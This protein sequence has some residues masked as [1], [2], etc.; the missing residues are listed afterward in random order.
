MQE[1]IYKNLSLEDLSGE[2]WR[3]V[4]GYEG[5]Y[6]VSNLGRVKSLRMYD[7][8]GRK[9]Y[10]S[11]L[12]Q[13]INKG[14]GY[15][16]VNLHDKNG[17]GL[18]HT[19]H[20]LV[21]KSFL[22]NPLNKPCIDHINT[23]RTDN[24]TCNIR[25]V[26]YSENCRNEITNKRMSESGK[27]NSDVAFLTFISRTKSKTKE[28]KLKR[29]ESMIRNGSYERISAAKRRAI[30]QIDLDGNI[31]NEFKSIAEAQRKT[32]ACHISDVCRGVRKIAGGYYWKFK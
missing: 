32:G 29:K 7:S 16:Y 21:A 13:S 15:C 10:I 14:N 1:E 9:R 19:I 17:N 2:E 22:P 4:V 12:K 28:A 27:R 31:V 6:Q 24:R 5:L 25:W 18:V 26:T 3:D 8:W 11:I 30:Y 20:R 23:V